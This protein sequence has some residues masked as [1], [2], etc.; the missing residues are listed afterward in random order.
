MKKQKKEEVL[1]RIETEI[2][3]MENKENKLLFY[4]FDTKGNPSGSLEYIYNLALMAKNNGYEV[5][6]LYQN[7]NEED[8]FVGVGDWLS[9]E[10]SSLPHLNIT[11]DEVKV[12]PSDILFIPEIF[13]N[14]MNQ[15]KSLPCK[16]VAIMQNIN[17]LTEQTPISAQWGDVDIFDCIVNT[18]ENAEL[19]KSLFPYVNTHLVNP[20]VK[21]MFHDTIAP[22][23]MVI[24]IVT[25]QQSVIN[26][27]VKPFYWRHP[28][29]KWVSFTDLRGYNK[30]KFADE[31]R[32]CAATI[33]V[34]E[35]TEFGL[36]CL[37]AMKSQSIVL[38]KIPNRIPSWAI[39]EDGKLTDGCLW[40]DDFHTLPD[41]IAAI[42]R[43]IITDKVPENFLS[44]AKNISEKY[45]YTASNKSFT[46]AIDTMIE[47][48]INDMK[49][50]VEKTN[51]ISEEEKEEETNE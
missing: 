3:K 51:L 11:K 33:W 25:R 38:A 4:I 19:I 13:F 46:N 22:K 29:Y 27:I 21:D 17:F 40:F 23:K 20:I 7:E 43:A 5:E 32:N 50:L 45:N 28:E 31:L 30:E 8:D 10:Y 18:K 47:H 34:D 41:K 6:M 2:S 49:N 36:S 15:C 9:E 39:T 1:N 14:V 16:K 37:E 12:S 48:R 26:K 35:D 42:V 44:E 24:N